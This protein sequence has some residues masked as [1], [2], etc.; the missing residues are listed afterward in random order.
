MRQL[1]FRQ[2]YGN[3]RNRKWLQ[4]LVMLVEDTLF[5]QKLKRDHTSFYSQSQLPTKCLGH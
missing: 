1:E 3:I 5:V 4:A 2:N